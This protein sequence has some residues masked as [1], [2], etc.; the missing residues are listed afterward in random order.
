MDGRLQRLT[1]HRQ[2]S[3]LLAVD[4]LTATTDALARVVFERSFREFGLPERI[5][6]DNGVPFAAYT[7][8]RL[9]PLSAWWIRLGIRPELIEPGTPQQNASHERMHSTLKAENTRPAASNLR[10]QQRRS[11]C[12]ATSSTRSGRMKL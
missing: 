7:F 3:V 2:R 4:G 6:S 12:F 10:T 8:G 9:S 1:L 11:I 5:R